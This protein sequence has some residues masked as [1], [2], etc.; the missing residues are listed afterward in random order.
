MERKTNMVAFDEFFVSNYQF[1]STFVRNR[2]GNHGD[3]DEIVS[4]AFHRCWKYHCDGVE[5]SLALLVGIL[6]NYI[7]NEWR[8]QHRA[9]AVAATLVEQERI[10]SDEVEMRVDFLYTALDRLRISERE[11]LEMKYWDDMTVEEIAAVLGIRNVTA[12]VRLSRAR[13]RLE[14]FLSD[15]SKNSG[16]HRPRQ[17][18]S[19]ES[20]DRGIGT[21]G[22]QDV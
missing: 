6:R 5:P 20:D 16:R 19:A 13:K 3:V 15:S 9:R 11:I 7:G 2:V 21:K 1:A 14:S 12:R 17:T 4:S 22:G 8:R 18:V 10:C